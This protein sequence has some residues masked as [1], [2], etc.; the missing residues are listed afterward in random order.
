MHLGAEADAAPLLPPQVEQHPPSVAL[1][2]GEGLFQ[3]R[4]AVA[5]KRAKDVAR[6]AL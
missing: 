4:P 1:D 5:A 3:L 2:L 6:A